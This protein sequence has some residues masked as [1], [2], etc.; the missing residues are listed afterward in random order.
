MA[1]LSEMARMVILYPIVVSYVLSFSVSVFAPQTQRH[2]LRV[3]LASDEESTSGRVT[4]ISSV[5]L[6]L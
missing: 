5:L 4:R 6:G 3:P 1:V 2:G